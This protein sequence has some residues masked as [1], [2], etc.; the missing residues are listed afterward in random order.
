[1]SCF[2]NNVFNI[3]PSVYDYVPEYIP[4]LQVLWPKFCGYLP[5]PPNA[6]SISPNFDYPKN[7]SVA[8]TNHVIIFIPYCDELYFLDNKHLLWNIIILNITDWT[9][10]SVPSPQLQLLAPTHQSCASSGDSE[11]GR[12]SSGWITCSSLSKFGGHHHHHHHK[13]QGLDPLIRSVSTVTAA[14]T[15]TSILCFLWRFWVG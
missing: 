7:S 12:V 1:M 11:L 14:R 9:L 3:F 15:N 6:S 2:Q 13:H 8:N 10:W 4:F 5:F